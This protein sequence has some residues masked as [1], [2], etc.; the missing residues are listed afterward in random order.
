LKKGV[1][2]RLEIVEW[3]EVVRE[4]VMGWKEGGWARGG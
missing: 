2:A 3:R 4:V 1:E